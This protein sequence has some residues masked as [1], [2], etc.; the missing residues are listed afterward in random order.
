MR[1]ARYTGYRSLLVRTVPI[2][3]NDVVASR[4]RFQVPESAITL[5]ANLWVGGP[6]GIGIHKVPIT[7]IPIYEG[8]Y[9]VVPYIII[10]GH[11]MNYT[12]YC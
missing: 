6:M 10:V 8:N 3:Q 2:P 9:T 5:S 1:W 11:I 4:V 12:Y 7:Y